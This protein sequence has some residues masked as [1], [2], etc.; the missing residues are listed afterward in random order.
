METSSSQ[1]A[2]KIGLDAVLAAGQLLPKRA[3]PLAIAVSK[4]TWSWMKC[5]IVRAEGSATAISGLPVVLD[6]EIEYRG[7]EI[8]MS[9]GTTQRIGLMADEGDPALRN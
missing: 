7:A 3:Y 2:P 8:R 6:E 9:D 5:M 1:P 4:A